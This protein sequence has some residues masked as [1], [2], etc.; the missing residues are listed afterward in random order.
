MLLLFLKKE[1]FR[2]SFSLEHELT[3]HRDRLAIS[4][5]KNQRKYLVK[6]N[7]GF[8]RVSKVYKRVQIGLIDL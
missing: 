2:N 4:G 3:P 8:S 6:G 7:Y 5:M 1:I